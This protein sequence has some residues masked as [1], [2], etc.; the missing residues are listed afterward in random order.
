M[1]HRGILV[2]WP[3]EN[4]GTHRCL[5]VCPCRGWTNV[6]APPVWITDGHGAF[7]TDVDGTPTSN[8]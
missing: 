3:W 8:T 1:T 7:F 5:G 2:R 6:G 4:G